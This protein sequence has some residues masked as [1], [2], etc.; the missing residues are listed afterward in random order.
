MVPVGTPSDVVKVN[1]HQ[2]IADEPGKR[3]GAPEVHPRL[4]LAL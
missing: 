2:A 3:L 1:L 4:P